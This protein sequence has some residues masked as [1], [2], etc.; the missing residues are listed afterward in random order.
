MKHVVAGEGSGDSVKI[1]GKVLLDVT[2]AP[3]KQK[4]VKVDMTIII[5]L[6]T[7]E[8]VGLGQQYA[9]GCQWP[10]A[11]PLSPDKVTHVPV[12]KCVSGVF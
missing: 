8:K 12:T 3:N 9:E 2:V 6:V 11:Y 4:N 1:K 7:G 5:D 10:A